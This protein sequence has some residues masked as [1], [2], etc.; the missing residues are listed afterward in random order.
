MKWNNLEI[1]HA[2]NMDR[3]LN[4]LNSH[5]K[6]QKDKIKIRTVI[7]EWS[8]YISFHRDLSTPWIIF[9]ESLL[10]SHIFS[11]AKRFQSILLFDWSLPPPARWS[12]H[13]VSERRLGCR[14]HWF[15]SSDMQEL[16]KSLNKSSRLA[17]LCLPNLWN[18][19]AKTCLLKT[20]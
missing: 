8:A 10:S 6:K 18:L 1:F 2:L 11:T 19:D 5:N 13:N 12:P 3:S 14:K 15:L 20:L 17:E 9:Q 16:N 4:G 7:F